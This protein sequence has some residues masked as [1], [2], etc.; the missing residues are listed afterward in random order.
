MSSYEG[1]E[2]SDSMI[3]ASIDLPIPLPLI[4]FRLDVGYKI[5]KYDLSEDLTDN[6][7]TDITNKGMILGLSAKF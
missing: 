5:Q 3:M 6:I 4:D 7:S 2:L 1:S